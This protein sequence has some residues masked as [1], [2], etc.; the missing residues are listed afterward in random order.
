M[1]KLATKMLKVME[2]VGYVPKLG[3]NE[4]QNYFYARDADMADE[5]RT[6]LIKNGIAVFA[7]VL[8]RSVAVDAVKTKFG[9][10]NLTTVKMRFTFMDVDTGE[11][12]E[13]E[14]FGDGWDSGDK[15]I[16][17]AMTGAGKYC[18]KE[19]FLIPTGDDPEAEPPADKKPEPAKPEK[20][21]AEAPKRDGREVLLEMAAKLLGD[22]DKAKSYL[23]D[24]FGCEVTALDP[25]KDRTKLMSAY[26]QIDAEL[27]KAGKE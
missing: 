5:V 14:F 10:Q 4:S 25:I 12:F 21:K 15:G 1:N 27:K 18:L 20:K 8:E 26:T 24:I 19:T 22:A 6:A 9:A 16:Y 7:T 2:A 11:K 13:A 3:K 23:A 17:K